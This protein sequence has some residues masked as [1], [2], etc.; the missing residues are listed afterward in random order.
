MDWWNKRLLFILLGP[1]LAALWFFLHAIRGAAYP[2]LD[3]PLV[4]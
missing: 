1:T 2:F 4:P 3:L